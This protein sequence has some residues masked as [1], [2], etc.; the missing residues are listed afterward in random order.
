MIPVPGKPTIGVSSN[1]VFQRLDAATAPQYWVEVTVEG[2]CK[3]HDSPDAAF[4]ATY[5]AEAPGANA[6]TAPVARWASAETGHAKG[7]PSQASVQVIDRGSIGPYDYVNIGVDPTLERSDEGRDRLARDQRLR[8]ARPRWRVV[9]RYL[10][11]GLH[12][13]AFKLTSDA[14]AGA[15]ADAIRPVVLT[16]ESKLPMI[17][18]RPRRPRRRLGI[19]VWV[20]GPSQAVPDNYRSL[21]INDALLDWPT[22]RRYVA[23]TLPAGGVGP[24]EPDYVS[25]PSNYDAVVSAAARE[26]GGQG[27]VTELGGRGEPVQGQG[28]VVDGRPGASR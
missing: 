24:F 17:P 4:D 10:R 20:L 23:G 18:I 13:L 2:T 5:S 14:K 8:S 6:A 1:A 25:K 21:V 28:L 3:Q 27:F 26:A 16:Y 15:D 19:Q 9:G 7:Q 12:L 11:D 22:G